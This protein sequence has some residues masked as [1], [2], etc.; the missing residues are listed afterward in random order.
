MTKPWIELEH[1]ERYFATGAEQIAYGH[2]FTPGELVTASMHSTPYEIG[3]QTADENGDVTFVWNL[4]DSDEVGEHYVELDGELH[5]P[6]RATFDIVQ[7]TGAGG[8][9]SNGGSDST[10]A[11]S[12]GTGN[13]TGGNL[14]ATGG[15]AGAIVPIAIILMLAGA[16]LFAVTRRGRNGA[17]HR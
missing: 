7:Q 12:N 4:R 16:A 17:V 11:S 5:D 3:T 10:G 1:D 14:V 2:D 6:L 9:G 15:P 8:S 13:G